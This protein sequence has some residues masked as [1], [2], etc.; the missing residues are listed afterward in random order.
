MPRPAAGFWDSRALSIPSSADSGGTSPDASLLADDGIVATSH[1]GLTYPLGGYAPAKGEVRELAPG[2][3]WARIEMPGSLG[4]INVWLLDDRDT[5]GEGVAI[6]D[7]GMNMPVCRANWEALFAGPLAGR[8]VT[9]V[10]ATHLHPDHVGLA[11]WLCERFGV[12]LWM[13]RTE[14][15]LA[16]L[17]AAD[18]RAEPPREVIAAWR[19]AGWTEEQI[20][21]ATAQG[22]GRFTQVVSP[23]PAGFIRI[24]DGDDIAIGGGRWRVVVGSGHTPEHAC[25]WNSEA[26]L[27]IAGDQVLP[28]ITSNVSL[29]IHEPQADPLGDWLASIDRLLGLPADLLVLPAHGEPFTGLHTRLE[30]LRDGH[31]ARLDVLAAHI[32]EPKTAVECFAVLFDRAIFG[33]NLA[34]ATGEAMAHLRYLEVRGRARRTLSGGVARFQAA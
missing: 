11:G 13:T 24:A 32:R 15:L 22:W 17:L 16:R 6:V 14:W 19:A 28:R 4:H 7:T 5:E 2:V 20:A 23:F 12:P 10:I 18:A 26:G 1:R 3:G 34:L 27:L 25:L 33:D 29:T 21:A 31:L 30:A 9:R 8:R